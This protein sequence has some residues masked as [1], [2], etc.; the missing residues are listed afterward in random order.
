MEGI[1]VV[2]SNIFGNTWGIIGFLF[3][4]FLFFC[5]IIPTLVGFYDTI[6]LFYQEK[7]L[8]STF[9]K[10]KVEYDPVVKYKNS[11]HLEN[12]HVSLSL[13]RVDFFMRENLEDYQWVIG[14]MKLKTEEQA[15][16]DLRV[17]GYN[18]GDTEATQMLELNHRILTKIY[19]KYGPIP[20]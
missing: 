16:E 3:V 5:F 8:E 18:L 15:K 17:L 14:D 7:K 1:W 4:C 12:D 11:I 13:R 2:I 10:I 19:K 9:P 20:W 6:L